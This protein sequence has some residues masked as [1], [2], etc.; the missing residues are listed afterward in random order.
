MIIIK[1][2]IYFYHINSY[3]ISKHSFDPSTSMA[4]F[5]DL[6]NFTVKSFGILYENI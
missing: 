2:Y 4:S 6:K 3:G 1:I 5:Y